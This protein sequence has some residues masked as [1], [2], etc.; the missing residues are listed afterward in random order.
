MARNIVI[1][2]GFVFIFV[3]GCDHMASDIDYVPDSDT[4]SD[5]DSDS[6][7]DTET[8]SEVCTLVS[9]AIQKGP[10]VSDS[11]LTVSML[12]ATGAPTGLFYST[13]TED[14]LGTFNVVVQ[15]TGPCELVANGLYYNEVVGKLS[16]E[17]ITLRA[18]YEI[19]NGDSQK[20]YS[21]IFTHMSSGLAKKRLS[22]GDTV[23]EAIVYAENKLFNELGILHPSGALEGNGAGMDL[24][25]AN[26]P[27]NQYIV[28]L[29]CIVAK[30]AEL[31]AEDSTEVDDKLQMLLNDI[32]S[33]VQASEAINPEYKQ[34]LRDG[35]TA[36][37][38]AK[39]CIEK[40][41]SYL[42]NKTGEVM[43]IPD[44]DTC[45]DNDGDGTP[46]SADPD[47]D[48][49]GVPNEE[50]EAPYNANVGAGMYFD[51]ES[52]Y[53]WQ[54]V[55]P[56]EYYTWADAQ[57]YCEDLLVGGHDDWRMPSISEMRSLIRGCALTETS[58]ACG[59][60]DECNYQLCF[61]NACYVGCSGLQGPG[62]GGCYWPDTMQGECGAYWS[63]TN[64]LT[65]PYLYFIPIF[66]HA[67]IVA[68]P[69]STSETSFVTHLIR[70]VRDM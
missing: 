16:G 1:L 57:S 6:D 66:S 33:Q 37:N 68:D 34:Y 26:S 20:A 65:F 48:G 36:L 44:P 45:S 41:T 2:C 39:D 25:G 40:L 9:G 64:N 62:I 24:I 11:T 50:D 8:E 38:P 14:D 70:C 69:I 54:L 3:F 30:S 32:R 47:I 19:F 27:D 60:T 46:N 18:I 21:N 58:G 35:E 31:L 52:G 7:S 53:A 56:A 5:A 12:N 23:A 55:S 42:Y 17:P 15:T 51:S 10:F 29:S 13:T 43:G 61:N 49:D 4:S 67:Y 59:L 22:E 28:A 63:A